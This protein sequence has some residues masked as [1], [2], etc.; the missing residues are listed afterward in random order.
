[1]IE[2]VRDPFA[3]TLREIADRVERGEVMIGFVA[4]IGPETLG[5]NTYSHDNSTMLQESAMVGLLQMDIAQRAHHLFH[6]M[7]ENAAD[8][9]DGKERPQA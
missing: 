4:F 2:D 1:M 6:Q 3:A 8:L 7:D 5:M 9:P